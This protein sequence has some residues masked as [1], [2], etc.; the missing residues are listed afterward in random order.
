[1]YV[2][3]TYETATT[4]EFR[5]GRTETVRSCTREAVDFC[6]AMMEGCRTIEVHISYLWN[7]LFSVQCPFP[8]RIWMA[9]S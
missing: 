5:L 6:V 4:R 7:A 2:V 1:M 8:T 3:P 9:N